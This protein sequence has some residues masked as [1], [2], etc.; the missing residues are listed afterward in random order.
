MPLLAVDGDEILGLDEGVDDLQLIGTGVAGD[1][2][3]PLPLIHH[4][5]PLA[6]K[7][8]DHVADGVLV[9]RHRRG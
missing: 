4:L 1:V 3:F 9:P 6:V 2:Q 7:L 5:G 8:V